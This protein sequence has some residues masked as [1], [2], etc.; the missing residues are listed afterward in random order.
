M[1]ELELIIEVLEETINNVINKNLKDVLKLSA[2]EFGVAN[3]I[4]DIILPLALILLAIYFLVELLEKS[5]SQNFN[6]EQM[7]SLLIKLAIGVIIVQHIDVVIVAICNI[8]N[9]ILTA[10]NETTTDF[11]GSLS[12]ET[13][14]N[15]AQSFFAIVA[16]FIMFFVAYIIAVAMNVLILFHV[17]SVKFEIVARAA[18]APLGVADVMSGMNSGA[19]RYIKSFLSV[20]LQ[21]VIILAANVICLSIANG[22]ADKFPKLPH[23]LL[24]CIMLFIQYG[25]VKSS[26]KFRTM[27]A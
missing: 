27:F 23:M 22:M 2:G 7:I 16:N 13:R 10:I 6:A 1:D 3:T 15:G 20:S 14:M 4:Y 18:F 17:I 11:L 8:T 5:T 24:V 21:L 25:A 26:E 12:I 9:G 19:I